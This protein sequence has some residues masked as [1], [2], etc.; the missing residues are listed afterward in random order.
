MLDCFFL[1]GPI[2]PQTCE[3]NLTAA[4]LDVGM[5]LLPADLEKETRYSCKGNKLPI[6]AI[7]ISY[8][9]TFTIVECSQSFRVNMIKLI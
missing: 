5:N 8:M 1:C 9:Y 6:T 3:C 7:A 2:S 4:Y